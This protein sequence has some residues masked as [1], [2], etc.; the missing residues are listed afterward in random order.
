[1]MASLEFTTQAFAIKPIAV[2]V[3]AKSLIQRTL[4]ATALK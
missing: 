3:I 4:N 2:T 1:M